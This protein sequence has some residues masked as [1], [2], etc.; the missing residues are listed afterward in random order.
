MTV[1][2]ILPRCTIY[3]VVVSQIN[4]TMDRFAVDLFNH[5]E[6]ASVNSAAADDD[7]GS[8]GCEVD[9]RSSP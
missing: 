8:R 7:D 4:G 3:K 1:V 9:A 6:F 5:A 2:P